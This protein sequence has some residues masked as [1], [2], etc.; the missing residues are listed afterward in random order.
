MPRKE[1]ISEIFSVARLKEEKLKDLETPLPELDIFGLPLV[2]KSVTEVLDTVHNPTSYSRNW[3][4]SS[5]VEF[6][7]DLAE[8]E[9]MLMHETSMYLGMLITKKGG[10]AWTPADDNEA[11]SVTPVNNLFHSAID[12]VQVKIGSSGHLVDITDYA[13]KAYLSTLLGYNE[14]AKT[15]HL[16]SVGWIEDEDT[17]RNSFIAKTKMTKIDLRGRLFYDFDHQCRGIVGGSK[18]TIR[19]TLK[20]PRFFLKV[21]ADTKVQFGAELDDVRL[22][23]KRFKVAESKVKAHQKALQSVNAKYPMTTSEVKTFSIRSG[24]TAVSVDNLVTGKM[25]SRMYVV[26]VEKNAYSGSN[27]IDPFEFKPFNLESISCFVDGVQTPNRPYTADFENNNAIEL[28]YQMYEAMNE[29]DADTKFE[30]EYQDFLE[31]KCVIAFNFNPD[32]SN[33]YSLGGHCNPQKQ[34]HMR[35]DLRFS[36]A[37]STD[38]HLIALCEFD[39]LY[40]ID[41]FRNLILKK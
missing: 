3:S 32:L 41:V 17:R 18:V 37:L 15:T 40:E 6:V 23:V 9:Y 38:I 29:H 36:K 19:I 22:Y 5:L 13:Y 27:T 2:Q 14:T 16:R 33:G 1:D 31:D 12:R 28:Y 20:S 34:G 26:L 21:K 35:L 30:I 25:P 10:G 7:I 24:S 39:T 4:S 8:N 11:A